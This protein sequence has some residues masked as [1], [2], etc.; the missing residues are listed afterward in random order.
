[1]RFCQA[2]LA[3]DVPTA[4][5]DRMLEAVEQAREDQAKVKT[6]FESYKC[7]PYLPAEYRPCQPKTGRRL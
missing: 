4:D 2:Y 5:L 6:H 7:E 1:M 3:W